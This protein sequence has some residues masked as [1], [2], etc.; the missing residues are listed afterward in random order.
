MFEL[1]L[2][3]SDESLDTPRAMHERIVRWTV[4]IATYA[5]IWLAFSTVTSAAAGHRARVDD[6][7][8]YRLPP[9]THT[10]C[11]RLSGRCGV[12]D[13]RHRPVGATVL[14]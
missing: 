3:E 1:K 8:R 9:G 7:T 10:W 6:V 2:P 5:A 14:P 11:D 13:A 4:R 12:H